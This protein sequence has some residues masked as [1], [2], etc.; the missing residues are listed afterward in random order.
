MDELSSDVEKPDQQGPVLATVVPLI[1]LIARSRV[2][3]D[4]LER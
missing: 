1:V 2:T 3:T 4:G